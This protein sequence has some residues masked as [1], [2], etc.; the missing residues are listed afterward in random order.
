MTRPPKLARPECRGTKRDGR[1]CNNHAAAGSAY[2][3]VHG[4][5]TRKIGRPLKLT[6]DVADTIA[7]AI[8]NGVTYEVAAATAQVSRPAFQAWRTQGL[9]DLEAGRDTVFAY[10]MAAVHDARARSEA[11]LVARLHAHTLADWRPAAW[12]LERRF[13]ERWGRRDKVEHSGSLTPAVELVA[14][15]TEEA[16]LAVARILD[17]ARAIKDPPE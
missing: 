9:D 11:N 4:G 5:A 2:C 8:A 7:E 17:H 10:L 15:D 3:G 13:P 16:A 14:P 6:R 1:P 12:L